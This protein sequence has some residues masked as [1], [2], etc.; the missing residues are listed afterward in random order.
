[1]GKPSRSTFQAKFT[2][3]L[4]TLRQEISSGVYAKGDFLP[5]ESALIERFQL[6]KNSVRKGLDQ[7]VKEGL[8]VKIP[9]VGTQVAGPSGKETVHFFVYSSLY[10]E[11][12]LNELLAEFH[13]QHPD[14][15][16]ETVDFRGMT[17]KTLTDL[18]Q[19][20]IADVL[21]VNVMDFML[22]REQDTLPLLE[23]QE[24]KESTYPFLNELFADREGRLYVQPFIFSPLIACY[25]KAHLHS[26]RLFE[27]DGG[28]S[29]DD[30]WELTR[31]LKSPDRYGIFF[32]VASANRWP[33]FFIQND[34]RFERGSGG[35]LELGEDMLAVL[36]S[37]R[38]RIYEDG[39][40]PLAMSSGG[41][42]PEELFKQQKISLMLT[43]YFRLNHLKDAEFEFD[44]AQLPRFRNNDTLLFCTALGIN[45]R[46]K[47]KQAASLL[48]RYL[49]SEAAQTSIRKRTFSLPA[50][51]WVGDTVRTELERKPSRFEL[52]REMAPKYATYE[53]LNLKIEEMILFGNALKQYFA[54][55][56]DERG[57]LELVNGQLTR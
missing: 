56:A 8:I 34:A 7:L 12:L 16:V 31:K 37:V 15:Q 45:S 3:M 11:V 13:A 50:N 6:S 40:F 26:R 23:K 32:T 24:A 53:R 49:T 5:P 21:A 52:Y 29:W 42:E 39:V 35:G 46:S 25:N 14:I 30:L 10:E 4:D 51:K 48:V 22:L 57:L 47:R 18:L 41:Q 38:D 28:W 19:L 44:V 2:H 54:K 27:P 1:M 17:A 9:R 36:R 20:G 33:V 43:T 55:M